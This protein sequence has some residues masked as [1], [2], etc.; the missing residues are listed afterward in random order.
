MDLPK[1][2]A[3]LVIRY[4]YLWHREAKAGVV[5]GRKDRPCAIILATA[6]N[7]VLV[8]PITHSQ[9]PKGSTAIQLPASVKVSLGLDDEMS[10]VVTSEL[11]TFT[12][13]GY[14]IRPATKKDWAFGILP[15]NLTK[16]LQQRVALNA[17]Q[18]RL[19]RTERDE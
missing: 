11:N 6:E 4:S 14:D 2:Q 5:E 8:I 18:K 10:W 9:P 13:P 7:K 12:W 1:P 15:P 16:Q 3:G 17:K 19:K